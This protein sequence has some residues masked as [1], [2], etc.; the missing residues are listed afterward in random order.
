[1]HISVKVLIK[2]G[3]FLFDDLPDFLRNDLLEFLGPSA[4]LDLI[5]RI[6]LQ[7]IQLKQFLFSEGFIGAL[8]IVESFIESGND[9]IT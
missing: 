3:M 4:Y 7:L 6:Y 1:M 2:I 9:R 5:L 8:E